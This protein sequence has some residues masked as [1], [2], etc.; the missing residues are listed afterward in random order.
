MCQTT[1]I[2]WLARLP[3]RCMVLKLHMS[4]W[5]YLL[6][7]EIFSFYF[8]LGSINIY[9]T[10]F[11]NLDLFFP[12][13]K[14]LANWPFQ[15]F[16]WLSSQLRFLVFYICPSTWALLYRK[17]IFKN[18]IFK[19]SQKLCFSGSLSVIIVLLCVSQ[20]VYS[21]CGKTLSKCFKN[22]YLSKIYN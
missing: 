3:I 11:Y 6:F 16:I 7:P 1:N 18:N 10:V 12:N 2:L 20:I 5:N 22:V 4:S 19:K 21:S 17:K 13:V 14:L 9:Q 8:L 15:K